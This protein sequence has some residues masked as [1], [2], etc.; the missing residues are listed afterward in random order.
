MGCA[1]RGSKWIVSDLRPSA[2]GMPKKTF[3]IFDVWSDFAC[4]K[5]NYATSS[6]QTLSFPPPSAVMGLCACI[7]G[8]QW[9]EFMNVYADKVE[10]AIEPRFDS[11]FS[12]LRMSMKLL[13]TKDVW[14]KKVF[15]GKK[16]FV[17]SPVGFELIRNPKYRVYIGAP[18]PLKERLGKMLNEHKSHYTPYL[19]MA[20][21]VANF[22]SL[23][24]VDFDETTGSA[25]L[26]SVF[27][28]TQ[29]IRKWHIETGKS[30]MYAVERYPIMR[31]AD[32]E[33]PLGRERDVV[34][35]ADSYMPLGDHSIK[36]D[37]G[38]YYAGAL[39]DGSKAVFTRIP[40]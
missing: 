17:S 40:V 36:V 9:V 12:K 32:S 16:P 13:I 34:K 22:R 4:F 39:N 33:D 10:L 7:L 27:V 38:T 1:K 15:S 26:K 3:E 14:N 28:P 2:L 35:Y 19:G 11:G 6:P 29:E 30:A 5:A 20:Q 18:S 21:F 8:M 31:P 23:G 25:E 24:N 37:D